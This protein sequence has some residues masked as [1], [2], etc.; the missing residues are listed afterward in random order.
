MQAL[1]E[2][3]YFGVDDSG[4]VQWPHPLKAMFSE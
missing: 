2:G 3:E 4:I 1:A